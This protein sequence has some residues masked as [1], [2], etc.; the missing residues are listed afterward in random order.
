MG[1]INWIKGVISKMFKKDAK[2]IFSTDVILSSKM[3]TAISEW[4]NI[5][6][7]SP[8]WVNKE[9]DIETINFAKF[10]TSDVA[11]KICLDIGIKIDG[12]TRADYLQNVM[13]ATKKVLRDKVEDA[14]GLG[15]IMFKPNGSADVNNCIDYILPTDFLI[16]DKTTNGDIRGVIFFDYLQKGDNHFTRMEYHRFVGEFYVITNKAYKS[17]NDCELGKEISLKI[18]E[19]WSNI[20]PEVSI[21]KIDKPLFAYYK[22]PYNNTIDYDSPLGVSVYS[23]AIKELKALDIAWSRKSGEIED[24]KHITFVDS[25]TMT[26][27]NQ[28]NVTLPRFIKA[29]DLD[30]DPQSVREHT[31]TLLTDDRISD[32][33]NILN[34]LATKIG[35]S[36]GTWS[37]DGK[38]GLMTATQV[39]AEDRE[40]IE[41]IKDMR[42]SL[43]SSL[44]QLLYA[45]DVYASLY[46]HA[47]LGK[48]EVSYA[49]GDLTYN[50]EEDRVRHWNYVVQGKYPLYRYYMKFEGMSEE[51]AKQIIKEAKEE[52]PKDNDDIFGK[53]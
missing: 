13:N 26:F 1:L 49:F 19:E 25:A 27:A 5:I 34:M 10:I 38:T 24:S 48:Y 43:K 12:S 41:T 32:M 6:K 51:E 40:T 35:F 20:Q 39:E 2:N 33:N 47:P 3:E 45:I 44:E 18:V 8:E 36:Q 17:S 37:I 23:N 52:L 30:S 16:T 28:N 4:Y 50:W 9:D 7:E 46:N 31:A 14:C 42:D 53:E 29:I 15:G 11:K 21:S 22:M